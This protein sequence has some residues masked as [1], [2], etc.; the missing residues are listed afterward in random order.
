MKTKKITAVLLSIILVLSVALCGCSKSK[1]DKPDNEKWLYDAA[2]DVYYQTGISYC[3]KPADEDTQTLSIFVP[4]KYMNA[5]I[6][7]DGT[8]VC[9]P[10]TTAQ[11][12]TYTSQ[13]APIVLPVETLG[14]N[15]QI[16]YVTFSSDVTEYTNHGLIYVRVGARGKEAGAP[17]SA[18]DFKAA[19]KYLRKY[20]DDFVGNVDRIFA[21]GLGEGANIAT[22]LG[23]SGDSELYKDYLKN[24]G[25]VDGE[26]DAIAGVMSWCPSSNL[27]SADAAYEWNMGVTRTGLSKS[28][29]QV[30]DKLAEAYANYINAC[31]LIGENN[32]PLR[33][34]KSDKGIY[35]AGSYYD[36]IKEII[37]NSLNQFLEKVEFP[38]TIKKDEVN[39]A[40]Q[41]EENDTN[42]DKP[43]ELPDMDIVDEETVYN[44]NV[45]YKFLNELDIY[46]K[47]G[48]VRGKSASKLNMVGTYNNVFDYIDA[49]NKNVK[50][51]EYDELTNTA[52]I[53]SVADFVTQL[54]GT[55]KGLGAFDSLDCKQAENMLFA[56]NKTG[57]HFDKM[58][59]EIKK[60]DKKAYGKFKNDA[61]AEDDLGYTIEQ[62]ANMYNPMYFLSDYY[63]GYDTSVVAQYWRVRSG[64][65]QSDTALCSEVNLALALR[66]YGVYI[67]FA[68]VWDK[69]H[70]MAES[71]GTPE[72][73]FINWI[74][75]CLSASK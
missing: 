61:A 63:E 44:E 8:Y 29:R 62:R 27:D 68:T 72:K 9:R 58:L 13:T 15:K 57:A 36:F 14:Y 54:K 17:A 50:W 31:K 5:A 39:N 10:N 67:D 56:S 2:Y 28:D 43:I 34:E 42:E 45:I 40:P 12:G 18:T 70:I 24:I 48:V 11:I 25:A 16:P 47:D 64:I 37:E 73:N 74:K 38:Y 21:F 69:G 33:L 53:T 65:R 51:V 19:I 1:L 30:S 52:E 59:A 3:S 26:S 55:N 71:E 23:A 75:A 7:P 22:V 46:S 60:S 32:E 6:N 49:L 35:Q 41:N 4:G 66:S 20:K